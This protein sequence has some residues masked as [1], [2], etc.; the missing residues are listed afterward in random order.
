MTEFEKADGNGNGTIEKTE[1]DALDY[2][3]RRRRLEDA[4]S[5]RDQQRKMVWFAL[6]G[7]LFYPA[8]IVATSSIGLSE[9]TT[10]LTSIAGVYFVSVA[11]LVGAF[12]GFS[13]MESK[14]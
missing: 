9:A 1:W 13:S 8:A 14:K 12:F 11:G 4:D 3:D 2:E 7:L 5:K 6:S 10:S